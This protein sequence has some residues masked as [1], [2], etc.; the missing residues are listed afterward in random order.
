M[1]KIAKSKHTNVNIRF[2]DTNTCR[3]CLKDEHNTRSCTAP[4]KI[5]QES[6]HNYLH[7]Q[8]KENV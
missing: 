5:C 2:G 3:N 1:L 4:C 6:G 8:N 7:C